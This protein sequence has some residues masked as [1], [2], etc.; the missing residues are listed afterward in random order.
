[1]EEKAPNKSQEPVGGKQT[2]RESHG[3]ARVGGDWLI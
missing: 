2:E 3:A 1:M